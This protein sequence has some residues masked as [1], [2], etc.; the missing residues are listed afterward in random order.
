[1]NRR[2]QGN[3]LR[4][5]SAARFQ[6]VSKYPLAICRRKG[7][8]YSVYLE[9]GDSPISSEREG[10][11]AW[12]IAACRIDEMAERETEDNHDDHA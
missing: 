7:K 5:D 11:R 1:M 3:R 12:E 10:L 9:P 2:T 8:R 6:V 4:G